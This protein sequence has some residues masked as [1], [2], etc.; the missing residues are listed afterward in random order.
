[1][2]ITSHFPHLVCIKIM[3]SCLDVWR[4]ALFCGSCATLKHTPDALT[5]L[6]NIFFTVNVRTHVC[7]LGPCFSLSTPNV[8]VSQVI[9][10][11]SLF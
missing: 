3:S 7:L 9:Q 6:S 10:T 4:R 1:M 2:L 8:N 11:V 5:S